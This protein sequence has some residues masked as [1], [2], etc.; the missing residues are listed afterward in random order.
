MGFWGANCSCHAFCGRLWELAQRALASAPAIISHAPPPPLLAKPGGV[1]PPSPFWS[2]Q[3]LPLHLH[4]CLPASSCCRHGHCI[5]IDLFVGI[6]AQHGICV[7]HMHMHWC[8]CFTMAVTMHGPYGRSGNAHSVK[9]QL[10]PCLHACR[11]VLMWIHA[12]GACITHTVL[13]GKGCLAGPC[14][15]RPNGVCCTWLGL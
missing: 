3:T 4:A 14:Y 9:A 8:G 5:D 12:I 6:H 13:M 2:C 7:V 15:D 11:V 1:V 10:H